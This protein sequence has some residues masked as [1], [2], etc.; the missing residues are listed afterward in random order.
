MKLKHFFLAFLITNISCQTIIDRDVEKTITSDWE[1]NYFYLN[2]SSFSSSEIIYLL[3]EGTNVE[4]QNFIRYEY[5]DSS[6]STHTSSITYAY[7]SFS[8]Q[9]KFDYIYSYYFSL[10]YKTINIY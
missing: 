3:I 1:G 5:A 9:K 6:S 10:D 2:L 8:T 4:M 7:T